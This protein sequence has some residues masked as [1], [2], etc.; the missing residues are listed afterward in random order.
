MVN[1]IIRAKT[2]DEI[3]VDIFH[4][5]GSRH[6]SAEIISK[7]IPDALIFVVS[8]NGGISILEGGE[9]RLKDY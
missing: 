6:Q 9:I 1:T 8:E 5:R 4:D 7:L 3:T 2:Q